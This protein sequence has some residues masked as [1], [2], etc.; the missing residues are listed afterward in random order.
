MSP[1]HCLWVGVFVL[2]PRKRNTVLLNARSGLCE[3]CIGQT[4]RELCFSSLPRKSVAPVQQHRHDHNN[5]TKQECFCPARP[6][7]RSDGQHDAARSKSNAS[8][9]CGYQ[10]LLRPGPVGVDDISACRERDLR[11]RRTVPSRC[12]PRSQH[13][14]VSEEQVITSKQ[15]SCN[16]HGEGTMNGR[17]TLCSSL[18]EVHDAGRP[19]RV[20]PD[21]AR[22][23]HQAHV[24]ARL[25][26]QQRRCAFVARSGR[27]EV[28]RKPT[29]RNY[30][31]HVIIVAPVVVGRCPRLAGAIDQKVE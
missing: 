5:K 13:L 26:L 1:K 6:G 4:K 30:Y 27:V 10:H 14:A 28:Y 3:G 7:G 16:R 24:C 31:P 20:T 9:G 23:G 21:L 12:D 15:R 2:L 25:C 19:L 8:C 17:G 18:A 11:P 22:R 29:L